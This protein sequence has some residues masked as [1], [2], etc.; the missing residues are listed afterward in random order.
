M[1]RSLA[2]ANCSSRRPVLCSKP[3]WPRSTARPVTRAPVPAVPA[4]PASLSLMSRSTKLLSWSKTCVFSM[5]LYQFLV[6][7]ML[8]YYLSIYTILYYTILYYTILYYTILLYYVILYLYYIIL[9]YI[10]LCYIILC[11]VM[12]YYIIL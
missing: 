11:Y 6:P 3:S 2:L 9:C 4:V 12:L 10:M 5:G 1:S 8:K 7:K